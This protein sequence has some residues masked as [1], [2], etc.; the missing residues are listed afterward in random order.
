MVQPGPSLIKRGDILPVLTFETVDGKQIDF[1]QP[2]N[3]L[4]FFFNTWCPYS[5]KAVSDLMKSPLVKDKNILIVAVARGEGGESVTDWWQEMG[6]SVPLVADFY[7][8]IFDHFAAS[9]VP[10]FYIIN[11]E[12]RVLRQFY[13]WSKKSMSQ[14]MWADRP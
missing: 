3:K 12:N 9:G 5:K 6:A 14:I 7:L 4:L 10:R 1:A 2:K 8:D 11:K 13:G